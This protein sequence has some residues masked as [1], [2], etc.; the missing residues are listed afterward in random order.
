MEKTI[1]IESKLK[2]IWI[3]TRFFWRN[4]LFF[5]FQFQNIHNGNCDDILYNSAMFTEKYRKF[6]ADMHLIDSILFLFGVKGLFSFDILT[7]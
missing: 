1:S 4:D 5:H 6:I 2:Q 7:L 3:F